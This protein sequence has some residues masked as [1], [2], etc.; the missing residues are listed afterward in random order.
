VSKGEID[1]LGLCSVAT[2]EATT[3]IVLLDDNANRVRV[4]HRTQKEEQSKIVQVADHP[5]VQVSVFLRFPQL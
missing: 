1:I 3:V 2:A 5:V 4:V